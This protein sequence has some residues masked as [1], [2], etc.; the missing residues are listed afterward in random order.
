M[1]KALAC[2]F[3]C[4]IL[5]TVG[6]GGGGGTTLYGQV[7]G[8]ITDVDG[9]VVR[10]AKVWVDGTRHQTVTNSAGLYVLE[11][12]PEADVLIRASI[13]RNG[14]NYVGS[15][16]ARVF[17]DERAKSTNIVIV[18]QSQTATVTARVLDN[19][20]YP[21][22]GA[23]VFALIQ[24]G[25]VFSSSMAVTDSRGY[26]TLRD[27]MAGQ[28]YALLASGR[29][30]QS[31][32]DTVNLVP[33]E[34]YDIVFTLG[35]ASNPS[36]PAPVNLEAAAWTSPNEVSRSPK[37][38]LALEAFK[39]KIDPRRVKSQA[40]TRDSAYGNWVEV[41][42]YWDGVSSNNLLGY[43]IY[44]AEGATAA[45]SAIDY[46][47]DP[48]A[49]YYSDLDSRLADFRTYSYQVTALNTLYGF[50]GY[51]GT[52]SE[53]SERAVVE[54]LS[55]LD[56]MPVTQFPLTFKWYDGSG[57]DTY[58]VYLFNEY[59]SFG[60]DWFWSSADVTGT[61]ATY[62]GPSLDSGKRYYF[63]VLGTKNAKGNVSRTVS[64]VGEFVKN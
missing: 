7:S 40:R 31:D 21:L 33:G 55:D 17:A 60:I 47:R 53:K 27:L 39:N 30:Y 24:N 28:D 41:D 13:T 54:T 9:N 44:R 51:S 2:L 12:V 5:L 46:L 34:D 36:L 18:R 35:N 52:E 29:G 50:S 32:T 1:K 38:Q 14:I 8:L 23:R 64:T 62:N 63:I 20:G 16:M 11:V 37:A 58:K 25:N 22:E 43:G 6:C 56:L 59:P 57:A 3:A 42:L 4:M 49:E 15:N 61:S 10:G 48:M 26:A 19:Q 45:T